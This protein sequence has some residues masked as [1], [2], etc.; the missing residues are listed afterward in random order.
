MKIA[1]VKTRGW[2]SA[3]TD[4]A[5]LVKTDEILRLMRREKLDIPHLSDVH[6]ANS[7]RLNT[8]H[9]TVSL[10][11]FVMIV[12]EMSSITLSP[13][14]QSAWRETGYE[15]WECKEPGRMIAVG[16]SI[17]GVK[18]NRRIPSGQIR[19]TAGTARITWLRHCIRSSQPVRRSYQQACGTPYSRGENCISPPAQAPKPDG[20]GVDIGVGPVSVVSNNQGCRDC[21]LVRCKAVGDQ[22]ATSIESGRPSC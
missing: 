14:A 2:H 17:A 8:S 21:S 18:S 19:R 15:R 12:G 11:E 10:E 6:T 3:L 20:M 9:T 1:T 5:H 22:D 16:L 4:A 13:A 7:G